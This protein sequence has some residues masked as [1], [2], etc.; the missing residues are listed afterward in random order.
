MNLEYILHVERPSSR[1][2]KPTQQRPSNMYHNSTSTI[3]EKTQKRVPGFFVEERRNQI[4]ELNETQ[5]KKLKTF[6][7]IKKRADFQNNNHF[8]KMNPVA[9]RAPFF[10]PNLITNNDRG[11]L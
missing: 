9:I 7:E 3:V 5:Q 10:T 1:Y 8:P 2:H 6:T 11:N 4:N